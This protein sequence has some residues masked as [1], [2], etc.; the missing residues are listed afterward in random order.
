MLKKEKNTVIS[1][2]Q[3]S[4]ASQNQIVSEYVEKQFQ[5]ILSQYPAWEKMREMGGGEVFLKDYELFLENFKKQPVNPFPHFDEIMRIKQSMTQ[6]QMAERCEDIYEKSENNFENIQAKL[7]T[8][9]KAD[10][11]DSYIAINLGY[12]VIVPFLLRSSIEHSIVNM[13]FLGDTALG[14]VNLE[15]PADFRLDATLYID[16]GNEVKQAFLETSKDG[17]DYYFELSEFCALIGTNRLKP[18]KNEVASFVVF[19]KEL[20]LFYINAFVNG[21]PD[22]TH[23]KLSS[24][25]F[26]KTYLLKTDGTQ[27]D[28]AERHDI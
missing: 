9:F 22:L 23:A 21:R 7:K 14:N 26:G 28:S 20:G 2:S 12:K 15:L 16:N 6:E 11:D 25:N 17:K 3:E 10:D 13:A 18:E 19:N 24:E 27:T 1:D 8:E 4:N 5:M